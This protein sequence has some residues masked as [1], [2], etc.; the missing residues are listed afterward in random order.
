M[1]LVPKAAYDAFVLK[2]NSGD[3]QYMRQIN[4]VDVQDGGKVTIRNDDNIKNVQPIKKIIFPS[5]TELNTSHDESVSD[6]DSEKSKDSTAQTENVQLSTQSTQTDSKGQITRSTQTDNT[7]RTEGSQTIPVKTSTSATQKEDRES[8]S[9]QT[10]AYF[11]SDKFIQAGEPLRDV[12][13][14][15]RSDSDS[16]VKSRGSQTND[17]LSQNEVSQTEK[18]TRAVAHISRENPS[19]SVRERNILKTRLKKSDIRFNPYR[20]DNRVNSEGDEEKSQVIS[21]NDVE[22]RETQSTAIPDNERF[23]DV[24]DWIIPV[25]RSPPNSDIFDKSASQLKM[26][27]QKKGGK[28]ERRKIRI[29]PLIDRSLFH[30]RRTRSAI[31][32]EAIRH[33]VKNQRKET[34]KAKKSKIQSLHFIEESSDDN[35]D[36]GANDSKKIVENERKMMKNKRL[37]DKLK[38]I[39]Q[40]RGPKMNDESKFS[41]LRKRE[42]EPSI[43]IQ[44]SKSREP[45]MKKPKDDEDDYNIF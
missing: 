1:Y 45:R 3:I 8:K 7:V 23:Q 28:S 44:L 4:N 6:D 36:E 26:R 5:S 10:T 29:S 41:T 11:K 25:N 40:R 15:T 39:K 30:N 14:Q 27:V 2:A 38:D 20:R 34:E 21:M 17:Q 9:T 19:S 35:S 24:T 12:G 16:L 37:R 43:S 32:E 22:M 13:T 18:G 42:R 31:D 33:F